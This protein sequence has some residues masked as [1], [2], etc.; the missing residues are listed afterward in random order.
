MSK[1]INF[2]TSNYSKKFLCFGEIDDRGVTEKHKILVVLHITDSNKLNSQASEDVKCCLSII[3]KLKSFS[4]KLEF[5]YIS[6]DKCVDIKND[7]Y[8]DFENLK[9][10]V[11]SYSDFYLNYKA[12]I[13][14]HNNKIDY[15]GKKFIDQMN[16]LEK[17]SI[18][19]TENNIVPIS[20]GIGDYADFQTSK[21]FSGMYNN[22][23]INNFN[24]YNINNIISAVKSKMIYISHIKEYIPAYDNKFYYICNKVSNEQKK[25]F[26]DKFHIH[27]YINLVIMEKI[28]E[29]TF[30]TNQIEEIISP[31][32][33]LNDSTLNINYYKNYYSVMKSDL[34]KCNKNYNSHK[35][36]MIN[37]VINYN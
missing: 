6:Y 31:I 21:S 20:I 12:V 10:K 35:L 7:S 2:S 23:L 3:D 13:F 24:N 11:D 4:K 17:F 30:T 33:I 9:S 14:F 29:Q 5:S 19:L 25:V 26:P 15:S 34:D 28:I 8:S 16:A 36:K 27:K 18:T 32:I 37:C 22:F 1:Y